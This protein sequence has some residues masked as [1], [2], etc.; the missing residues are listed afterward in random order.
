[1]T[2]VEGWTVLR[3]LYAQGQS[4]RAIAKKIGISRNAE[5][6]SLESNEPPKYV[7]ASKTISERLQAFVDEYP[8]DA[9]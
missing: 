9:V 3:Y 8:G 5:S 4:Q 6:T 2:K 7:R 1:M